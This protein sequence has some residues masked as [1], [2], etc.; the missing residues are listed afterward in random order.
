MEHGHIVWAIAIITQIG[1]NTC[2]ELFEVD[3]N[4]L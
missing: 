2:D 1:I 3:Y 4:D